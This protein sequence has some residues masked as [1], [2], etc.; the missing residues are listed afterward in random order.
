MF[1]CLFVLSVMISSFCF[2]I[3]RRLSACT[4]PEPSPS[5]AVCRR[6][7]KQSGGSWGKI[8]NDVSMETRQR[9]VTCVLSLNTCKSL[10]FSFRQKMFFLPPKMTLETI[11]VLLS[12]R[13]WLSD[14]SAWRFRDASSNL[15]LP[16]QPQVNIGAAGCVQQQVERQPYEPNWEWNRTTA[17]KVGFPMKH[18]A[19]I[20]IMFLYLES[21]WLV[22]ERLPALSRRVRLNWCDRAPPNQTLGNASYVDHWR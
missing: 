4:L 16:N 22:S 7:S 13:Q 1:V 8:S 15:L 5:L 2:L 9:G 12:P 3:G 18:Q 14:Q 17:A 20:H 21:K 10:L 11:S 19:F 6:H